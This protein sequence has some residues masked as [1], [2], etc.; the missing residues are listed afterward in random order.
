MTLFELLYSMER[1][2]LFSK[3][4]LKIGSIG[5]YSMDYVPY[6]TLKKEVTNFT[7][8][9]DVIEIHIKWGGKRNE[10]K[11]HVIWIINKF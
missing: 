9:D 6:Y 1:V 4:K 3:K 5:Y 11:Y 8:Y 7:I 10:R 2:F